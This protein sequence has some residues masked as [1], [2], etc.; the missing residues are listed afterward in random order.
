MQV[1]ASDTSTSS[2]QQLQQLGALMSASHASCRDDYQC[3]CQ[4]LDDLVAAALA[5]GALG[6]RLTGDKGGSMGRT[7]AGFVWGMAVCRLCL[8]QQ[9]LLQVLCVSA[10]R[11]ARLAHWQGPVRVLTQHMQDP[12]R[13]S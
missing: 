7:S 5:G 12:S 1:C 11:L 4:E 3:S 9:L 6:A 13:S 10:H 8:K 2:E